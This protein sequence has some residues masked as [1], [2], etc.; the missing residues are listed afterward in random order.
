[1]TGCKI[2]SKGIP[3]LIRG[4]MIELELCTYRFS[5]PSCAS[6]H[7]DWSFFILLSLLHCLSIH[8]CI[9]SSVFNKPACQF[10]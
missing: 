9:N 8:H 7:H 3:V 4:V 5:T 1:M 10:T 2:W 6:H